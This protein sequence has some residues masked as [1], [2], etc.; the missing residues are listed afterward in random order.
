MRVLPWSTWSSFTLSGHCVC[1]F[2]ID[3]TELNELS[4]WVIV[5][6][7]HSVIDVDS[8]FGLGPLFG[9]MT[10]WKRKLFLR[11]NCEIN[12]GVEIGTEMIGNIYR[13]K[14]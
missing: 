12:K 3:P 8:S 11:Q 13:W 5:L 14:K 2:P 10:R 4:E 1:T 6:I 7:F 9:E